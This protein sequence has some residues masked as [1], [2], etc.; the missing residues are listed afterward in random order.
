MET[1]ETSKSRNTAS[2][3]PSITSPSIFTTSP[4]LHHSLTQ[5][6]HLQNLTQ[7]LDRN[8]PETSPS[9]FT[10][11]LRN[12][13]TYLRRYLQQNPPE[14]HQASKYL[15]WNLAELRP[16][17]SPVSS[18]EPS[19]TLAGVSAP[20]HSGTSPCICTGTAG[21]EAAPDRTGACC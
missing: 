2:P 4:H 14:P 17:S 15:H 16:V 20:E 12:L 21:A 11:T 13:G 10:G 19:R 9:I 3:Q 8:I 18:P 7:H 5:H 1:N 6:I